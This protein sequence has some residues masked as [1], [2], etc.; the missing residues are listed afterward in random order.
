[1]SLLNL[2]RLRQVRRRRTSPPPEL[3][4][5]IPVYRPVRT[6]CSI[7][8]RPDERLRTTS[9]T[10]KATCPMCRAEAENLHPI[11]TAAVPKGKL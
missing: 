1:M 9:V 11:R 8:L 6:A 5:L 2:L 3:V 7:K 4:H 10:R